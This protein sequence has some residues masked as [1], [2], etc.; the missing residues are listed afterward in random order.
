MTMETIGRAAIICAVIA[1]LGWVVPTLA[2]A[3]PNSLPSTT[4]SLLIKDE[5]KGAAQHSENASQDQENTAKA[6]PESQ[7][8]ASVSK[9][10]TAE[11]S[12]AEKKNIDEAIARYTYWLTICTAVLAIATTFLWIYAAKQSKDMKESVAIAR[13]SMETSV[14]SLRLSRRGFM[15]VKEIVIRGTYGS[16]PADAI[17][18]GFLFQFLW[19]N[20]GNAPAIIKKTALRR[21]TIDVNDT[22]LVDWRLPDTPETFIPVGPHTTIAS[23][24]EPLPMGIAEAIFRDEKRFHIMIRAEYGDM[25]ESD[26]KYHTQMCFE[27]EVNFDPAKIFTEDLPAS[28]FILTRAGGEYCSSA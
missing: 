14:A 26:A 17:N 1:L 16:D 19:E 2:R 22:G 9:D 11:H 18:A 5:K 25:F 21:H 7:F 23:M 3:A 6:L 20:V 4:E 27:I 24:P 12:E 15:A 10:R 28:K 8:G 13:E